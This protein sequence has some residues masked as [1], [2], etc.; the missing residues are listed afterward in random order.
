MALS[1]GCFS[2]SVPIA[3]HPAGFKSGRSVTAVIKRVIRRWGKKTKHNFSNSR[4]VGAESSATILTAAHMSEPESHP[5]C[6]S[7]PPPFSPGLLN[8]PYQD[9]TEAK[10]MCHPQYRQ[11]FAAPQGRD[12]TL[13][14]FFSPFSLISNERGG[15]GVLCFSILYCSILRCINSTFFFIP[16]VLSVNNHS[17]AKQ[18][19]ITTMKGDERRG[20]N[21]VITSKA[22]LFNNS[23]H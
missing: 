5:R 9:R 3:S 14:G 6:R 19:V 20:G 7:P 11:F 1:G 18:S 21:I 10:T 13:V 12:P 2:P 22:K 23:V 8:R 16:Y 17:S 4:N 15:W